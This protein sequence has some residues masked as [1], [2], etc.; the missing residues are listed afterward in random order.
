MGRASRGK[1]ARRWARF[2]V[3]GN[4][5]ER[6]RIWVLFSRHPKWGKVKR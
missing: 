2:K 6:R 5:Q 4:Q 1:W 3:I